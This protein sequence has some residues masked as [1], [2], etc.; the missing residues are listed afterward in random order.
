[1][2]SPRV[3]SWCPGGAGVSGAPVNDLALLAEALDSS[4]AH[5]EAKR[6][7]KGWSAMLATMAD[8][9]AKTPERVF[10]AKVVLATRRRWKQQ[11]RIGR[12]L[13]LMDGEGVTYDVVNEVEPGMDRGQGTVVKPVSSVRRVTIEGVACDVDGRAMRGDRSADLR[14]AQEAMD[15]CGK[16]WREHVRADGSSVYVPWHCGQ[17]ICPVCQWRQAT[18]AARVMVD[19]VM[20]AV[21][22]GCP[23]VHGTTTRRCKAGQGPVVL[24]DREASLTREDGRPF[25]DVTRAT[26]QGTATGGTS[27]LETWEGLKNLLATAETGRGY[28]QE[29]RRY[30]LAEL[31]GIESTQRNEAGE[32][33]WHTHAHRLFILA[34]GTELVH[35]TDEEGRTWVVGG[36]WWDG[37]VAR[38]TSIADATI[39]GQKARV[40]WAPGLDLD[41]QEVERGVRQTLK[42]AAKLSDMTRAGI[43]EF[44]AVAK[45][46]HNHQRK[47]VL[48]ASR[49]LGRAA[50]ALVVWRGLVDGRTFRDPALFRQAEEVAEAMGVTC[51]ETWTRLLLEQ[52]KAHGS[53]NVSAALAMVDALC[54]VPPPEPDA[55]E[56]EEPPPIVGTRIAK[57]RGQ[58]YIVTRSRLRRWARAGRTLFL[59]VTPEV[60]VT[61]SQAR[62]LLRDWQPDWWERRTAV[63]HVVASGMLD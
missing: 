57:L 4:P 31:R 30:V 46:L 62:R 28:R 50:R 37:W 42:Y 13:R 24:T 61:D 12:A 17:K 10:A 29:H 6:A 21:D 49:G 18:E 2:R 40:V 36:A 47:G 59:A 8:S 15:L 7:P 25:F 22:M 60:V 41:R 45:G 26:V 34:P 27:L 56:E 3:R 33:R 35:E 55:E 43:A 20:A 54:L 39:Q 52:D 19:V 16:V 63:D 5:R 38:W 23:V 58:V 32:V 14:K 1:M 48:N 51:E 11:D 53:A 9:S 44:L